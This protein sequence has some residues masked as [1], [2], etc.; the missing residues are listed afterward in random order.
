M[1]SKKQS[2]QWNHPDSPP[3]KKFKRVS[4]SGKMIASIFWDCQ[5]IIMID[6]LE[7]ECTINCTYYADK[8][9]RLHQEIAHKMRGKLIQGVLP[10]HNNAPAHTSQVAMAAATDC[11]FE[12]LPHP[13]YYPGVVP[14]D[15]Q[16]FLILKTKLC[17]RCFGSNEG[18]M[19]VVNEFYE[20]QNRE[21][22]FEGF[23]KLEH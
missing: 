4:T 1:K 10:L 21:L 6:Y 3:L 23:N 22:Y 20:E 11:R 9:R 19:E 13:L 2:I 15:F 18:V 12:I 14:S 7:Q 16:L 5:E 8:L 17:A